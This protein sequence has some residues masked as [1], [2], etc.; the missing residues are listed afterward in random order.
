MDNNSFELFPVPNDGRFSISNFN[1]VD[2]V[3]SISVFNNLG[4]KVYE[5]NNIKF[6]GTF[7]MSL[8][9]Q[10]LPNGVYYMI[11]INKK[12]ESLKKFI[13]NK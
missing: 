13:V 11:L 1:T 6:N 7:S 2:P 10:F 5:D 12:S 9:L 4:I 3:I 8:N